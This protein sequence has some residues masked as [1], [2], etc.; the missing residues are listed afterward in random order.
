MPLD[1][2]GYDLWA[3]LTGALIV[4]AVLGVITSILGRG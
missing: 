1:P 3:M 4:G 2:L